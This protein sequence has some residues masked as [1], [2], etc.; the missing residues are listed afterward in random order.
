VE[1]NR[2]MK[3]FRL[4]MLVLVIVVVA[5]DASQAENPQKTDN[6][7][8]H[9][10]ADGCASGLGIPII[11]HYE[12][13]NFKADTRCCSLDGQTCT[14]P[15]AT[16]PHCGRNL[17]KQT[18][19]EASSICKSKKQRL[20][21][22]QELLTGVCCQTGGGCDESEVWTSTTSTS[23][24]LPGINYPGGD[25]GLAVIKNSKEKCQKYCQDTPECLYFT[26]VDD[27]HAVPS[28]RKKCFLKNLMNVNNKGKKKNGVFSGPKFCPGP[29]TNVSKFEKGA[30]DE[31]N[32]LRAKHGS[33]P[34]I[35]DRQISAKAEYWAKQ[36][37]ASAKGHSYN[38]NGE[39][40]AG[41]GACNDDSG[42]AAT[43]GWYSEIKNMDF[44]N[45]NTGG[46]L[47]FTQVVWKAST[48][49][50]IGCASNEKGCVVVAR[51][52]PPGN[53]DGVKSY[54]KNVK[55]LLR[56]V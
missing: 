21:T 30:L 31:H 50:G 34:L 47:H 13:K 15:N 14:T 2:N 55:P 28:L 8:F 51:Y 36:L 7:I 32:L 37:L 42:K 53:F 10:V 45:M 52:F 25:I 48:H 20:C 39:N 44:E 43:K 5:I 12:T 38:G 26:W 46:A 3:I 33:G 35:L 54:R 19:E 9:Y 24:I 16:I 22:D 1:F 17:L 29:P 49:I 41:C 40:I 6:E 23:C 11:G 18:F 56:N 27:T 4:S